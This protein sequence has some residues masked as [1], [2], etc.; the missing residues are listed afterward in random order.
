[1]AIIAACNYKYTLPINKDLDQV[2]KFR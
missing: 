1:V 2:I